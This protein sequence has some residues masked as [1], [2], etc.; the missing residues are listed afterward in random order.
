MAV[1]DSDGDTDSAT[2]DIAITDDGPV[3]VDDNAGTIAEDAAFTYNVLGNDASGADSPATLTGATLATGSGT[4]GFAANGDITFTPTAGY[5]GEVVIDYTITDADGDTDTA[6]LTLN[7]DTDSVPNVTVTTEEGGAVVDESALASGTNAASDGESTSGSFDISTGGDALQSLVVGGTD[8][9]AD[10]VY[11]INGAFGD[12]TVTASGG[13]YTWSYTLDGAIDHSDA[14]PDAESFS[15]AVTDSDGDT[16]SATLDI[17][18]TDDGPVAVADLGSGIEGGSVIGNVLTNDVF[19]ADGS[20]GVTGVAAG[21]NTSTPLVAGVGAAI[22]GLYGT[23]TLN[24]DGSYT[25]VGNSNVAP[26]DA[27][28]TFAYTIADG[29]G[30][31]STTTLTITMGDSGL[32]ATSDDVSV[33]EAA[34]ATGSNSGSPAE[35]V[36]GTLTD[37][38]TGGTGA[39]T[40]AL[41]G[42]GAGSYGSLTLNADGSYSY[43]LATPFDTSPDADNGSH[44]ENNAETFTYQVTDANGN[45][46]TGAITVDIVDDSPTVS[47]GDL[48]ISNVADTHTGTFDLVGGADGAMPTDLSWTNAR[49]GFSFSYDADTQTGTAT[50]LDGTTVET[51]FTVQLN[52]DGSYD[53]N[54]VTP[55]PVTTH[56][57]SSLLTGVS[58]GS[59]LPSYTIDASNFGDQ[60]QLV[61][62]GTSNGSPGTITISSND[63]GVNDNV[64]HGNKDDVLRFDVRKPDGSNQSADDVASVTSLTVHA[65][66]T[67]GWNANDQVDITV[68]YLDGSTASLSQVWGSDQQITVAFDPDKVVDYIEMSPHGTDAFKID[69]VSMDYTLRTYPDDYQLDFSVTATDGD[70]DTASDTFSVAVDASDTVVASAVND[71]F[72][73][74]SEGLSSDSGSD[75]LIGTDGPDVFVW[76]LADRGTPGAPAVDTIN[77]FD[78]AP[79]SGGGDALDLRDLLQSEESGSLTDYLH[80][81]TSGSDTLVHISSTGGFAGGFD[82][83]HVDQRIELAG[84]DLTSIGNDQQI[85]QNLVNN[86]KLIT[87]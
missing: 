72:E 35:T 62:T 6:T 23:L 10:G 58:G 38:V 5:E 39:L 21:S 52:D 61:L 12:L 85:I 36:S 28:D 49:D 17:A 76:H 32:V 48:A 67:A 46:A 40:Y 68:Q 84:V 24:A 78:P 50:F 56:T 9:T 63:L 45:T 20:G 11:T 43:T 55:D 13:V 57:T 80:F 25:Y 54:L 4:V 22:A 69:G 8:V 37:N 42:S 18:I 73:I 16:D 14:V 1:T 31:T 3:A 64:L 65:A 86:G 53:F 82:P 51:F 44:T 7:V 81:E 30:D 47:A 66:A 77:G 29:D 27:V 19:G 75:T 59:N 70:G 74:V 33:D 60:F 71:K 26:P 41:V 83:G 34:L 79:V 87:D 2:L 15:V